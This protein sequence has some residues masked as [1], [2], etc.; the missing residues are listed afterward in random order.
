MD[1]LN[2]YHE[3]E[4]LLRMNSRYCMDDGRLLKN[5]I[6]EDAL[7]IQPLLVKELLGNEKMK[8]VFFTD[9]EGVMVFDKIKFQR[10]VSDTQF[11]GGSYTM[12]KNKIGLA[13]ENGRFVSES[14][15]VVLSWPYKD[16]MLEGGQTKE[17][18]KRNEVFWNETLA[19][20]EV[21]RLTEPKVFSNF[22][23]Y[24]KEGEHQVDHLSDND[25]LIIKGNNLLALHSLK[26]KYAGQV[27]LI[28]I[29]PP[30]YFRKKLSTDTFKYNSNFHL[31]TWL[32]F[33]R[34]RLECAKHLLAPSGTIW[35]HMGDEGM[36]YLKLVADQVFGINHFIGTLPRRTRNGKSDVPFNFSQDFDWLLV[37]TNVE[38]SQAVMGRAVERKY[39]T[40]EDYPGKPWRL[41]DLTKQTT[42][43]EREN[44]FFTMVDPKTG[45]EYPPSEK[46]TWCITKETFD[47]H[48]K[49]GYIVFPD[50]YD[51]L[52]ITKPYSRKFKYEDEANGKL[53]SIIS[54][55]QIQ[56]FL[57][58]LL[59]DC[60]N[61]IGNNEINDLFG[62]DEFDYA[63]PENLIKI[64]MEAVT[65]EGDLV[66]DF[67]SGSGT[68]VAVA[69][70]L[71]RKYIGCE[72]IDHQIELTVNRL[73]EVICGEQGG[74][75]KSIGWQGGGSFVYCELS[76][77]NG[78]FADEIENAETTGQLM[79]IW[80]RMKATDYLN[81]KVD[82]KEVD[83]NVADFEGLNLDDQKRFLIECLDKNL[84]YVPL[85]DIDSNE[86]GVTDE[87]KRLT[88]EFY[89]KN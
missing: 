63:K 83:A 85:S 51:F 37:Y 71:G 62:R 39:Y 31:S 32:T 57:K 75:S 58:S 24:D 68:T 41:A 79:D 80:N 21:N 25:N 74:V 87:D 38:E 16:C 59:Y 65:N 53:S 5:Q 35:I 27:K 72:Q 52:K 26:K 70:K 45:K 9:V 55:C 67:F 33:M 60:K 54:D 46:R 7:S 17:D 12:F 78:K 36:H 11:L 40:T 56:Q 34:D 29:D 3:L 61:E 10:F 6:V 42:A 8:K 69:H 23:R 43:K 76:K 22:K 18:A 15:E 89:H 73:N 88:R 82:I 19:P 64:I 47:S 44:S 84:L 13:N 4:Q 28:Y 1:K 81:Y 49:R 77:A 2:L 50:D 48:Y 30:Y 86:Y 66:M 20:D 14:R